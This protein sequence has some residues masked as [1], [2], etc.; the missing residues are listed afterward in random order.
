MPGR[1]RRQTVDG[2]DRQTAMIDEGPEPGINPGDRQP[3]EYTFGIAG[4]WMAFYRWRSDELE[5]FVIARDTEEALLGQFA[6]DHPP[7]DR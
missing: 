7:V 2:D 5:E 6:G 4:D 1:S 3:V